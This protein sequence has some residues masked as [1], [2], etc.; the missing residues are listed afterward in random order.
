MLNQYILEIENCLNYYEKIN[1]ILCTNWTDKVADSFS[2]NKLS[3]ISQSI[4]QYLNNINTCDRDIECLLQQLESD[5]STLSCEVRTF[6]QNDYPHKGY[7]I[8]IVSGEKYKGFNALYAFLISPS[9]LS[10]AINIPEV[11]ENI[12]RVKHPDLLTIEKVSFSGN[13]L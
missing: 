8:M 2:T 1:H 3:P 12:A 5:F 10:Q 13:L 7:P 4:K 6:Q 9:Q 11:G